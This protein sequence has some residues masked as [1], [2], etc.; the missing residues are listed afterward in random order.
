MSFSDGLDVFA[1]Q[2]AGGLLGYQNAAL[3]QQFQQQQAAQSQ[4]ANYGTQFGF[5]PG[6]NWM[7]WGAGGPSQPPAGTPTQ[8]Q[9]SAAQ[10]LLGSQLQNAL[11]AAGV[12]GQF[13]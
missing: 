7:Q 4:A 3:A 5:A 12:T 10:A 2:T 13:A 6:G 8:Q 11:A 9:Q 1:G